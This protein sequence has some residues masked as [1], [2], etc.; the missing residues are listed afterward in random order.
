[1]AKLAGICYDELQKN[2]IIQEYLKKRQI[3]QKTI[4]NFYLGAFPSDLRVLLKEFKSEFLLK[5]GILYNAGNSPFKLYPLI[6]PIWDVNNN[7]IG[8]GGRTLM[9]E[10]ERK[11]IGYPKYKNSE[12]VKSNN[13]FGLNY[14]KQSIRD[15]NSAII[16]EGYFDV[17]SSHQAGLV[18]VIAT[19]GTFLSAKQMLLLARYTENVKILFDNDEAGRHASKK[20]LERC[21]V[22]GVNLQEMFL[23]EPYKDLDEYIVGNKTEA[24]NL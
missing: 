8:L 20:Y 3:T 2:K 24:I 12:Y 7:F 5:N 14:A 4:D 9:S 15:K 11:D 17:I 19:S 22:D 23:P 16:V 10:K 21:A 18:N 1:M 13:L 6:I